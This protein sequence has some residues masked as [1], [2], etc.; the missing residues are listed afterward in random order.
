MEDTINEHKGRVAP[1]VGR[2]VQ[3]AQPV[4]PVRQP[5]PPPIQPKQVVPPK[6]V[7]KA[8]QNEDDYMEQMMMQELLSRSQ[9][10]PKVEPAPQKVEV[11]P[12]EPVVEVKPV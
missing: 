6:P 1:P 11:K 7:Q 9:E 12:V 4:Q 2:P 5:P 8:P 10:E 3:P